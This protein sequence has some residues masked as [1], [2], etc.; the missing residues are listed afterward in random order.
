MR[1]FTRDDYSPSSALVRFENH[2]HQIPTPTFLTR[3][4]GML[5][6]YNKNRRVGQKEYPSPFV[7]RIIRRLLCPSRQD[8][9]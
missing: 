8:R 1:I 5:K 4:K 2:K 3:L 6:E 9:A 7:K